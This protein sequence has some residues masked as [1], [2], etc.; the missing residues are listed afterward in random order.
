M[1]EVKTEYKATEEWEI[2][3]V[4]LSLLSVLLSLNRNGASYCLRTDGS[5]VLIHARSS[6]LM[7]HLVRTGDRRWSCSKNVRSLFQATQF[8]L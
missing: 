7:S 3:V 2:D 6:I 5:R 1:I 8:I 4:P